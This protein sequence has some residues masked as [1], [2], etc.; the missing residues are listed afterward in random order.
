MKIE[1]SGIFMSFLAC[2]LAVSDICLVPHF[3]STAA[4]MHSVMDELKVDRSLPYFCHI[5][6]G[7]ERAKPSNQRIQVP[8]PYLQG[9][10][11]GFYS[12]YF[13]GLFWELK[14]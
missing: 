9:E 4:R 1:T 14:S 11:D 3:R 12:A 7:V 13:P 6:D 5:R 8:V 2:S 10:N